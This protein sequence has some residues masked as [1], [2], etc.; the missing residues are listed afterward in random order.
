[1]AEPSLFLAS[2]ES[3]QTDVRILEIILQFANGDESAA[4][5]IWGAPSSMELIDILVVLQ[6]RGLDPERLP[7]APMGLLWHRAIQEII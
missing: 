1:M 6:N 2:A 7:W 4:E 3:R 5:R